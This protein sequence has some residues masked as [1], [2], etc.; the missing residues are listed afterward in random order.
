MDGQLRP[1]SQHVDPAPDPDQRSVL[2]SAVN[3]AI[4]ARV[5][6]AENARKLFV[7]EDTVGVTGAL[8]GLDESAHKI[9]DTS[10]K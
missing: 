10:K 9:L 4:S 1:V 5:C 3:E 2:Q 6:A 8:N 7:V